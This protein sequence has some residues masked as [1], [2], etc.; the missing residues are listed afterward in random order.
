LGDAANDLP[1]LRAVD[2]PIVVPRRDGRVEADLVR[3]LPRA[4]R[5]PLP[6]PAGW[7]EA[8]LAV[9]AGRTLARAAPGSG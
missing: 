9:L 6:G 7:N 5:A 4:E 2:R 8:V 1:L 3:A